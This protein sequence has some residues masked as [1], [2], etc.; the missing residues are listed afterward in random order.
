MRFLYIFNFCYIRM[1]TKLFLLLLI[2]PFVLITGQDSTKID[3]SKIISK[4]KVGNTVNFE[5]MSIKF[6]RFIEDSR[7]PSDINCIWTGEAKI[8]IEI[9]KRDVLI[10]EKELIF[11]AQRINPKDI[12]EICTV[13]QKMI[14]AY[15]L[16]PYP[17]SGKPIHP[18]EYYL[19]LVTK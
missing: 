17:L 9:Y 14:Y 5:N 6:L 19:E 4:I 8:V 15:N 11:G 13:K 12:K 16:G 1:R 7:C 10:E 3:A 18:S 2:A